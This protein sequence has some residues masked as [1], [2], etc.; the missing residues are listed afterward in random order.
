MAFLLNVSWGLKYI[1]FSLVQVFCVAVEVFNKHIFV[2][3]FFLFLYGLSLVAF[4]IHWDNGWNVEVTAV[5]WN[6]Q[7]KVDKNCF[8]DTCVCT[9]TILWKGCRE[10]HSCTC[11]GKVRSSLG[12]LLCGQ[13]V[14]MPGVRWKDLVG[15]PSVNQWESGPT[16]D[17]RQKLSASPGTYISFR[18]TPVMEWRWTLFRKQIFI[19]LQL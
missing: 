8:V 13:V 7:Y 14:K 15:K 9:D 12:V 5:L 1:F 4:P 6:I 17:Q 18:L 11:L 3:Y 2:V 16:Y 10:R 19:C